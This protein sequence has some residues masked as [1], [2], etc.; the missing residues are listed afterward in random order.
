M[1]KALSPAFSNRTLRQNVPMLQDHI[2]KFLTGI[3]ND[4]R[5]DGSSF[6]E[7]VDLNNWFN[8]L[9]FDTVSD[10]VLGQC[11]NCLTDAKHRPWL[12]S[13]SMTWH[14]I[15]IVS[16]I[17]SLGRAKDTLALMMPR[18]LLQRYIDQL[19]LVGRM[20][21]KKLHESHQESRTLMSVA[22]SAVKEPAQDQKGEAL[23]SDKEILSNAE[24][25]VTAGTDTSA[26]ALP[27]IIYLLCN[28]RTAYQKVMQEVRGASSEDAI[29]MSFIHNVPYLSACILETLRLHPIVPEGLPRVC[30]ATGQNVCGYW[31]PGGVSLE[32]SHLV[33]NWGML[34][35]LV[36]LLSD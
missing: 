34:T 7:A 17:K 15:S 9:A 18:K 32:A 22:R 11:F 24:L 30:H 6:G 14:F 16:S 25:V 28:N 5:R 13:L 26:T 33:S 12:K 8:W 1:R 19:Q 27:A 21:L 31:L 3:Q 2:T 23:L 36:D 29:D 20:A 35:I 10:F 4:S